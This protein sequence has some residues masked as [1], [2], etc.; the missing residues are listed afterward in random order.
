MNITVEKQPNCQATLKVEIPADKVSGQRQSIVSKYAGQARVPGF[1]PGKAPQKV[2]EKRFEKQIKDELNENL[3][4]LAIDEAIKKEDLK[5]LDFGDPEDLL[6]SP[7]GGMAFTSKLT[8]APDFPLPDYK[9]IAITVPSEDV[10]DEEI[11]DQLKQLQER[12]A[13]FEDIEDRGADMGDF[14]VIDYTSTV[15]GKPTEEFLGKSAGYIAGR[16]GF[17]LKINEDAFLPGFAKEVVGMKPGESKDITVTIPED[18]PIK[19]LIGKEVV[20]DTKLKELKTSILPELN[21]ELAEK[22]APGKSFEE[23]KVLIRE[24]MEH[25]RKRKIE[26]SKVN[27]VI[28][29]LTSKADFELPQALIDQETQSQA[30]AMVQRGM[31]SGMSEE[32][33]ASQ[34]AEIFASAGNQAINNLRAQFILQDIADAENLEVSDGELVTHLSQMAQQRN[35]DPKKFIK[36]LQRSG[37]IPSVRNSLLTRK[38]ID[39]VVGEAKVEVSEEASFNPGQA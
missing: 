27:Q 16:E 31:Q 38:A 24:N 17:W 30:D 11:E 14:G 6:A 3:F 35:Q 39:F 19:D 20:F 5:V 37:R 22:I 15:D 7:D 2:I 29:H 18:F 32:D 28:A 10:P 12:F 21:D 26:D 13:D 9:G 23:I 4:H 8:I 25:E 34:Q 33:I 36:E 1:R